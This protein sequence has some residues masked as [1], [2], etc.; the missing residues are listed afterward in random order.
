MIEEVISWGVKPHAV[1]TDCWY[2]SKKNLKFFKDQEL[3]F[4][5]G[6]AKNRQVKVKGG[7]YDRVENLEITEEGLSVTLKGF[8]IVKVFKR[9]FKNESCR[10]YA[11]FRVKE[12]ELANWNHT[13][14][15]GL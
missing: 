12:S 4:Q 15:R 5:V 11:T 9:T 13:Q 10:Y 3:S 2:A 14:F 7:K 1:T 8:G 6:I